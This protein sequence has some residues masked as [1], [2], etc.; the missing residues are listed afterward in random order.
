[1]RHIIFAVV[2]IG[3]FLTSGAALG[4]TGDQIS[5]PNKVRTF[6]SN[7]TGSWRMD[8]ATRGTFNCKWDSGHSTLVGVE[9]FQNADGSGTLSDIWHW[10][11]ISEDGVILNWSCSNNDGFGYGQV[12]GRYCL[13]P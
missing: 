9:Q 12:R 11:G 3:V 13:R 1:M 10:D 2:T 8:G 5:M 6:L 4:K 7:I